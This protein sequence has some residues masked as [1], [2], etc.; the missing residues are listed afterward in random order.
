MEIIHGVHTS[1]EHQQWHTRPHKNCWSYFHENLTRDV[2]WDKEVSIT[3]WNSSV[4]RRPWFVI[5]A[6]RRRYLCSTECPLVSAV[7]PSTW[8]IKK[9]SVFF[10]IRIKTWITLK[11]WPSK[12]TTHAKYYQVEARAEVH[13]FPRGCRGSSLKAFIFIPFFHLNKLS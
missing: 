1:G 13:F 11:F 6:A 7:Y 3:I 12:I 2:H 10:S 5:Q 8:P 4:E 9:K